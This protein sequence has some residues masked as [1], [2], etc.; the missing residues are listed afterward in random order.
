MSLPSSAV[1]FVVFDLDGTLVDSG[2]DLCNAV[3]AMLR[4]LN[5][6]ELAESII[7]GYIGDGA[8]ML[9]R[10]ALGYAEPIRLNGHDD[11]T[12]LEPE[13]QSALRYF[14]DW[15]REHKLDY[16]YA[17][18][19]VLE[20]LAAI[21]AAC[22]ELPMAVLTNKPVR[23]SRDICNALGLAPYFFQN[24]GGNSFDTKKP[25]PAGLLALIAEATGLLRLNDP[26]AEKIQPQE[27]V[28]VGDSDVD[29]LT[30]RNCGARSLG[31][32]F[33]LAPERLAAAQPDAMVANAHAWPEALQRMGLTWQHTAAAH[34]EPSLSRT[35]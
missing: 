33:G 35:V 19:G 1:R 24:Y 29:V 4:N 17:Y 26:A 15:Y 8:G 31:C 32:S 12:E 13:V 7:S 10:R 16:T 11:D 20:S 9:V 23:P 25:E 21:H 30:A 28:L 22:P 27:T 34:D 5:R 2:R 6:P 14:L 18:D 3:N